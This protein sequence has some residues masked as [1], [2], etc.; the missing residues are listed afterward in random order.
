MFYTLAKFL[1]FLI[2]KLLFRFGVTGRENIPKTGGFLIA[3]NHLSFLDPPLLALASPRKVF[4]AA[5]KGVEHALPHFILKRLGAFRIEKGIRTAM[6]LL[7]MGKPIVIFPEGARSSDGSLNK[8]Y[9]GIGFLAIKAKV[10]AIPTLIKG[11]EKA[12]PKK[13]K[14]IR[15][16][17]VEV[18]FGQPL[19][20]QYSEK[21]NGYQEMSEEVMRRIQVLKGDD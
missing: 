6:Q 13:G 15:P 11:T 12:L 18:I 10:P 1:G 20:P 16:R 9:S 3:A 17:K 14:M 2:F 5:K 21:K 4:Y 7:G 8:P 19:F